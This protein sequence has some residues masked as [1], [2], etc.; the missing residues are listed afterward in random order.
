MKKLLVL[1]S[2][3]LC[4]SMLFV[5]C[6]NKDGEEN[7]QPE[8]NI[9]KNVDKVVSELNKCET[10]DDL[11]KLTTTS[12]DYKELVAELKKISAEGSADLTATEDGEEAGAFEG[13]FAIKNNVLHAEGTVDGYTV[14]IDGSISDAYEL[15]FAAWEKEDGVVNIEEALGFDIAAIMDEAMSMTDVSS[16][17][18]SEVTL[19]LSEIKLPVFT[20]EHIT[21]EDGKYVLDKN[22]LYESVVATADALIDAAKDEGI[23]TEEMDIDAQVTEIKDQAKKIVDNIDLKIYY[24]VSQ[25]EITGIGVI[26]NIDVA[27]LAAALEVSEEE[28]GDVTSIKASAEM[29]ATGVSFNMEYNDGYANKISADVKYIFDGE[30]LCGVDA[31]YDMDMKTSYSNS[32]GD[33]DYYYSSENTSIMKQSIALKLDLSAFDKADA[34]V[35]D[36]NVSVSEDYTY[37]CESSVEEEN[38]DSHSVDTMTI[39]ASIKTTEANKANVTLNGVQKSEGTRNGEIDNSE[40]TIGINGTITFKTNDVTVPAPEA[41]VKDAMDSA[42]IITSM[43]GMSG[44]P[45]YGYEEEKNYNDDYTDEEW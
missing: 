19:D 24:L 5:A 36:L 37:K 13:S 29:S 22:F 45:D 11:L 7:L 4:L 2:L 41:D 18:G 6:G 14:G 9:E 33:V 16:M 8:E 40:S 3:I 17:M 43:Q 12:V 26:V 15:V 35:L 30:E 20:A 32:Y 25:E 10:L 27:K 34:T 28:M 39:T 21:Y 44:S 38:S 1:I 42:E 23:I 31:K